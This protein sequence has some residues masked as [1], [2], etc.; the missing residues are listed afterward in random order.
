MPDPAIRPATEADLPDVVT[1]HERAIRELGES[2]YDAAPLE[3]WAREATADAYPLDDD[4]KHVV[5]AEL[6]GEMVGVGQLDRPSGEV[7]KVFVHPDHARNG[8]ASVLLDHL[9]GVARDRGHETVVL[10]AS[11]NSVPF[12]EARDYERERPLT[13]QLPLDGGTA[14]YECVRMRKSL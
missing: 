2:H 13:K 9:E 4:A 8:V 5:V 10:D 1:V 12:Y 7:D 3:A 11:L 14:A 6:D